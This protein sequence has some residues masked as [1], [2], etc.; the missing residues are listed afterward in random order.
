MRDIVGEQKGY[1]IEGLL[2]IARLRQGI[3]GYESPH[4]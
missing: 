1:K 4:T 3:L 2:F